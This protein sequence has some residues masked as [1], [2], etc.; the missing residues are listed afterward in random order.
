MSCISNNQFCIFTFLIELIHHIVNHPIPVKINE[1][2]IRIRRYYNPDKQIII[3]YAYP[4][5]PNKITHGKLNSK[6][7]YWYNFPL[8]KL[9][10]QEPA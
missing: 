6:F 5:V 3:S 9:F 10:I 1:Q 8:N 4:T 2:P 7:V